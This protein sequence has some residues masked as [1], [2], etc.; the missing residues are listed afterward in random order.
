MR[1]VLSL[2]G[3]AL[4]AMLLASCGGG[5]DSDASP[6]DDALGY[7]P[8]DAPLA[9]ALSTDLESDSYRNLDLAL[10]RFGVPGG[11][12]AALGELSDGGISFS[13]DIQPLLGNDLVIGV[14]SLAGAV[15]A[16]EYGGFNVERFTAAMRVTDA[17]RAEDLLADIPGLERKEEIDGASVYGPE[18][19]KGAEEYAAAGPAIAVDGDVLVLAYSNQ[20]LEDALDQR[21]AADRLTEGDFSDRLGDLPDDGILRV[22]GDAP[23][24]LEALGIEQTATVPWVGAL[25]SFGLTLDV[26]GRTATAD[27]L[28]ST[29]PVQDGSLP[30]AAGAESPGL[31]DRRPSLATRD[32]SQSMGFALDVVRA[33]LPSA[34]FEDITRRV[35]K[36]LGEPVSTLTSQF[37]EGLLAELPSGETVT[38][39]EVRNPKV[40]VG[41]LRDLDDEVL[42]LAE[43]ASGGGV[44][45][46][47]LEP[48]R[49][50]MPALPVP[51]NAYFPDG[52]KVK[53]V[54]G[55][56][57][58][59][60]IT[61]PSRF[62]RQ[63]LVYGLLKGV[64]VTAPTLEAARR[65]A[66]LDPGQVDVP[67]G[68][69]AFSIPLRGSDIG[70]SE[71]ADVGIVLTTITGGIQ[72]SADSVRLHAEAAL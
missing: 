55:D 42:Q 15:E 2:L 53:P 40:V 14:P 21:Q 3:G 16:D 39:S 59:Y 10:Q 32:Q 61:S 6:L 51:E 25:R 47:A 52:S 22:T 17:A 70:L 57:S 9:V 62:Y 50:L 37:G 24:F 1:L 19:P 71:A 68:S 23:S 66:Q 34:A 63:Q 43:V 56:P 26:D 44:V 13:G 38:R 11:L 60:R 48:A 33:T 54:P 64:F 72:A 12:D 5:S 8:A 35:E 49:L 41:A 31:L 27:A 30:I 46:E 67:P 65:A 18:I 29:E 36:R 58:L 69:L 45:E 7:L 20:G 28:V 4:C